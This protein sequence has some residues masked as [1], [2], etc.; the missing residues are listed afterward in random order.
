MVREHYHSHQ[1]VMDDAMS[2]D[3][4]E[5]PNHEAWVELAGHRSCEAGFANLELHSNGGMVLASGL[6]PAVHLFPRVLEIQEG[7]L[8]EWEGA[9]TC[10]VRAAAEA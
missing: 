4:A 2:R 5:F 10:I 1:V 7:L 3:D 6:F 8:C 9:G